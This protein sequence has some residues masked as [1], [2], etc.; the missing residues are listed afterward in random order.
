MALREVTGKAGLSEEE[1]ATFDRD[2]YIVIQGALAPG[3]VEELTAAVDRT[4]ERRGT[5]GAPLHLLAFLGEDPA[6]MELLDQPVV[7]SRVVDILGPG[8][9][10]HHCHLDVHP[11]ET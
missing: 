3:H 1:R 11:P 6:F 8:I 9:F 5:D 4:Y 10:C 7:L 2:G